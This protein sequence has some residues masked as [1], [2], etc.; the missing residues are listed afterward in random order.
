MAKP[1]PRHDKN[2]HGGDAFQTLALFHEKVLARNNVGSI[3]GQRIVQ[4][5]GSLI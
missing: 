4:R 2:S 1:T 5:S 3:G